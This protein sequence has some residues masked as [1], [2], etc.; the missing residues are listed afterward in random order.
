MEGDDHQIRSSSV[1]GGQP[2]EFI[3][4]VEDHV[5][6]FKVIVL[7]ACKDIYFPLIYAQKFPEIMGFPLKNEIAAVFKIVDCHDGSDVDDLFQRNVGVRH[8]TS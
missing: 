1:I 7:L 3:W 8:R 5:A 6:P 4:L 2:M